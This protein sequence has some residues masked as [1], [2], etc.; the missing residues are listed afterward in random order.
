MAS[1]NMTEIQQV[2]GEINYFHLQVP[3]ILRSQKVPL[4]TVM[5]LPNHTA[6]HPQKRNFNIH[7]WE[8]LSVIQRHYGYVFN[9]TI[10]NHNVIIFM[11]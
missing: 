11:A 6:S 4:N 9:I 7:R 5:Y 2:F 10:A 3:Y 8:N 1:C